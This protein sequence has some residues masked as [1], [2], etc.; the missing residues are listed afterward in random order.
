MIGCLVSA[1]S[2]VGQEEMEPGHVTTQPPDVELSRWSLSGQLAN[3]EEEPHPRVDRK[4]LVSSPSAVQQSG[5]M[6]ILS[7]IQNNR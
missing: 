6:T 4:W 7:E 2:S 5:E 3:S 1:W